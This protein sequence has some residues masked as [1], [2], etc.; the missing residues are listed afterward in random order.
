MP[1]Q[2]CGSGGLS[3]SRSV[4]QNQS[5]SVRNARRDGWLPRKD[6][7]P[8]R[9][10]V[11]LDISAAPCSWWLASNGQHAFALQQRGRPNAA[12]RSRADR[13]AAGGAPPLP[14]AVGRARAGDDIFST[15]HSIYGATKDK[16]H[17]DVGRVRTVVHAARALRNQH[18]ARAAVPS[19]PPPFAPALAPAPPAN[20]ANSVVSTNDLLLG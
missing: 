10:A 4:R 3:G 19:R 2:R 11:T 1:I 8:I 6:R 7:G 18:P 12:D 9:H 15:A 14:G 16:A 20:A 13:P 5:C 17:I